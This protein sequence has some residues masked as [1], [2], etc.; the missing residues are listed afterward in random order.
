[1]LLNTGVAPNVQ[2]ANNNFDR[3]DFCNDISPTFGQFPDI[4]LTSCQIMCKVFRVNYDKH[5]SVLNLVRI[6]VGIEDDDCV[7]GLEIQSEASSSS[8]ENE[9]KDL[10]MRIVKH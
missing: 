3:H 1:M 2:L 5:W 9:Q 4:L 6:P 8:A 7:G 10:G